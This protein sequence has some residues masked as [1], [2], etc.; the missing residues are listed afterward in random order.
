MSSSV[1]CPFRNIFW[2]FRSFLGFWCI[3]LWKFWD[4]GETCVHS[5]SLVCCS[6]ILQGSHTKISFLFWFGTTFFK[7]FTKNVEKS[8]LAENVEFFDLTL[9]CYVGKTNNFQLFIF[10]PLESRKLQLFKMGLLF[11][12]IKSVQIL[13]PFP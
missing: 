13:R 8:D 9:P 3:F 2:I 4:F 11:I 1:N 12:W 10:V 6:T 5:F 7:F